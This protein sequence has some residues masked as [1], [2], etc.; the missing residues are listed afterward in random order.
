MIRRKLPTC[1]TCGAEI[2]DGYVR[3][4]IE[5]HEG[6]ERTREMHAWLCAQAGPDDCLCAIEEYERVAGERE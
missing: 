1:P 6:L 5:A 4:D 2:P 3:H